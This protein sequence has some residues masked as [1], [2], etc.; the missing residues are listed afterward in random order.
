MAAQ[1]TNMTTH[2]LESALAR[3]L[4]QKIGRDATVAGLVRLAG[5]TSCDVYGFELRVEG[6]EPRSL[7]LRIETPGRKIPTSRAEEYALLDAAHRAG[8]T[9]PA[10]HWLGAADDG[11]GGAFIVM[12][13]VEGEA[14]GR[15]LLRD[16]AYERTRDVLPA[17]IATELARAH[18]I[19][20]RAPSLGFLRER[21]PEDGGPERYALG[22]V[23]RWRQFLELAGGTHPWPV[24]ELVARWLEQHAPPVARPAL[25]HGDFRIGNILFDRR[26]LTAVLDWELAHIGDPVED[27][28]WLAVRTWRFGRDERAIGGLCDRQRFLEFYEKASGH[29]VPASHLRYWEL[30]GNWKWAIVCVGQQA[31]HTGSSHPNVELASLGRRIPEVELEMLDLLEAV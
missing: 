2:E 20:L 21:A 16:D 1:P 18:E 8:V 30:F 11:L 28:G 27:I 13:R 7:V 25:V 10:V 23:T 24:L 6:Q 26:G 22:E 17:Q 31:S 12:D 3:F 5:G 9:V 4:A 19:D 15:R 14:L 29:A